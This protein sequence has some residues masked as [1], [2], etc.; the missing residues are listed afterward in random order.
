MK[1][2]NIFLV[3][4]VVVFPVFANPDIN[5]QINDGLY[6]TGVHVS[7]A[8]SQRYDIV[9]VGDGFQEDEQSLFN[10]KVEDAVAALETMVPYSERMCAFNIWRV[11]VISEES[12][13]DHPK[14]GIFRDTE[15][16]CRYGNPAAGEAERCITSNSPDKCFEAADYAPDYD[17]VFVL[18]NDTQWGG[19][20]GS[21]VFSSI[22]SGF[23]G[24]VTHELGHKIGGLADEYECYVCDGSDAN[25]TYTGSEP[26]QP[27]VTTETSRASVKWNDLIDAATP[28]PTTV[29]SPPGVVGLWEGGRYYAFDVFRPQ[30]NC[31][32]RSTGSPFC[33][34]GARHMRETLSG[35]CSFCEVR[36]GAYICR[37]ASLL[38]DFELVWEERMRIRW[39]FPPCLT[40]PP[41]IFKERVQLVIDGFQPDER[42]QLLVLDKTGRVVAKGENRNGSLIAN[43]EVNRFEKYFVDVIT[44]E[45]TT[46]LLELQVDLSREGIQ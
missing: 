28:L 43:F 13:V 7:G 44:S 15:L 45:P 20:A 9:F 2:L 32:M 8:T 41:N 46:E 29:D 12:G 3:Y 24:I 27:N 14:D 4:F 34:V 17:A 6:Y 19:C 31:H 16:D 11:N 5:V 33:A 30:K 35:Y 26:G 10:S 1:S 23:A 37:Y 39:P 40:C 22:S 25:R 38:R 18:V 21:L 42:F 36:P